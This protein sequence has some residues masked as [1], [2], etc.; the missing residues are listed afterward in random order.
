MSAYF[1]IHLFFKFTSAKLWTEMKIKMNSNLYTQN[2]SR[3][4][5]HTFLTPLNARSTKHEIRRSSLLFLL[6]IVPA[7]SYVT[8][9]RQ[10]RF[11]MTSN[12]ARSKWKSCRRMQDW[13]CLNKIDS[14][15]R[16][17]TPAKRGL[18]SG[19]LGKIEIEAIMCAVS[20]FPRHL[21]QIRHSLSLSPPLSLLRLRV[22]YKIRR[23]V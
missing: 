22:T 23:V 20:W 10:G 8:T 2:L 12:L 6:F 3:W 7:F 9:S 18:T 4:R 11:E 16:S 14:R 15:L 21:S 13:N 17:S 5:F 1:P 19:K